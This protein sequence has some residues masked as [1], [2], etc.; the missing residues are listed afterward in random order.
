MRI[1]T[2][3]IGMPQKTFLFNLEL[4]FNEIEANCFSKHSHI[5]QR[6]IK[7]NFAHCM[8]YEMYLSLKELDG[9]YQFD[10]ESFLLKCLSIDDLMLMLFIQFKELI[11]K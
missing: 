11:L 5:L 7:A 1:V 6:W 9:F 4:Q 8:Y 3:L 2:N 10:H